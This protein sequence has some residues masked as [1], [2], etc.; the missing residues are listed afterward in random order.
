MQREDIRDEN[1]RNQFIS[2]LFVESYGI[3]YY[4]IV[5]A[6][7]LNS[8]GY[9][10]LGNME[11]VKSLMTACVAESM[12]NFDKRYVTYFENF[13]A[14]AKTFTGDFGLS[15]ESP[16]TRR[17]LQLILDLIDPIGFDSFREVGGMS[18]FVTLGKT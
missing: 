12:S 17:Q 1:L 14:E 4:Q 8:T 16:W 15:T 5:N 10:V 2:H 6:L 18:E 3:A 7:G 13:T 9:D 11:V